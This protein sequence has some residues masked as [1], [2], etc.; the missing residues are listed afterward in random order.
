M[1][2]RT[3]KWNVVKSIYTLSFKVYRFVG[4]RKSSFKATTKCPNVFIITYIN[5]TTNILVLTKYLQY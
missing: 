1:C 3:K 4:L 2:Q 5:E